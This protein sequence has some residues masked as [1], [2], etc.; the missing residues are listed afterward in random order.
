MT[1]V[2]T[3]PTSQR[4]PWAK[5]RI[6]DTASDLFYRE[7]IRQVG[8]DRLISLSSVTKATFYKHYRAKENLVV[9]YAK[10]LHE[11]EVQKVDK[12]VKESANAQAAL[13]SLVEET[14][15]RFESPTFRGDAF[16]NAAIE[17]PDLS[18]PIRLVIATHRDWYSKI[19]EELLAK[20]GHA[21]PGEGADDFVVLR[22]G[23]MVA[24]YAG[25]PV[26]AAG[27]FR[28]GYQ[29]ILATR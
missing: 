4:A 14:I 17:Y 7:G 5:Q 15:R 18:H 1:I 22:D 19:V 26:A 28:R 8:V 21:L 29:R 3:D 27:A 13:D 24:A 20:I 23:A 12:L 2:E 6:L 16:V 9:A 25:D 11:Q 10:N